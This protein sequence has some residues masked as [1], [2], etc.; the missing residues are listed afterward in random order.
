M[1]FVPASLRPTAAADWPLLEAYRLPRLQRR[2]DAVLLAPAAV[3]VF[4]PDRATAAAAAVDLADFHVGCRGVPVI[5]VA[6]VQGER[7]VAQSPLPLPGAAPVIACSRLLLPGLLAEVAGFPEVPGFDRAGWEAAAYRPVPGLM[8]AACGLYARHDEARLLLASSGRGELERTRT[9]V[10]GLIDEAREA[11]ERRVVFVTGRPGAGKTLC[12]LDV[13]FRPGG[14]AAFLTGN[15]ALLHVLRAALVRDAGSRGLAARAARQRV[16]AVIQPLHAFRDHYVPRGDVPAD[17]VLVIDEAQRCWTAAFARS[18]T[19]NRAVKLLE[20]EPGCILDVMARHEGWCVVVCL[21]GGGQE[22]HSGEGGLAAWGEALRQR[23]GWRAFAPPDLPGAADARQQLG[24]SADE[25]PALHLGRVVRAWAA[26]RLMEW[27]ET[28]LAEDP[29]RARGMAGSG[30]PVWMTRSLQA[31]R[32]AV[33]AGP[34]GRYGLV[35]SAGGRRLRAEG[36]GGLLWHQDEDAVARWFL[37]GWPDI[38]SGEALEVAATEFGVQGLELDRVGV[39]WDL[40]LARSADGQGWEPRAFRG[41][42]WTAVRGVDARA[43]KLNAY[44]VLLT[45]ARRGTVIWVPSGDVRDGT[46]TPARYDAVAAYLQACGVRGLD[47]AAL[48]EEDGVVMAPALL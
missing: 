18:K 46:R 25:R 7:V 34:V 30:L 5:P 20:S 8:E 3:V 1:S 9:A 35:A 10:L 27:V 29:A 45:R 33:R 12:G 2:I 24:V 23:S 38:R 42:S 21:V 43:N 37:D 14:G 22:I 48:A 26:P 16:E 40:D 41:T 32:A 44:R 19:K 31:M 13:A 39:C 28:V 36:L 11:G 17:R 4:G 47:E 15:P 6:V